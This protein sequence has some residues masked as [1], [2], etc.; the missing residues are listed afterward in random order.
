VV[1]A[2]R[3]LGV[4]ACFVPLHVRGPAEGARS[5]PVHLPGLPA[6]GA[7]RLVRIALF[8]GVLALF[9]RHTS[10][11]DLEQPRVPSEPGEPSEPASSQPLNFLKSASFRAPCGH[12]AG[13]SSGAVAILIASLSAVFTG[14]NM[15][16]SWATYRRVRPR[17]SLKPH[18]VW[19][20]DAKPTR[21]RLSVDLHVRNSGQYPVTL[22]PETQLLVHA[23]DRD[24]L[25][26]WLINPRLWRNF[27][28][29]GY[30]GDLFRHGRA[31]FVYTLIEEGPLEVLP[32]NGVQWHC[33]VPSEYID[34]GYF[35]NPH[36][37]WRAYVR[38]RLSDGTWVASRRTRFLRAPSGVLES[39]E[40]TTT[41]LSS[42]ISTDPHP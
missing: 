37:K 8:L 24:L 21:H 20:E 38:V 12:P 30:I 4:P 23:G 26:R 33:D 2:V 40:T 13:M 10:A 16:A 22:F 7:R 39:W 32:F 19:H 42:T 27:F 31:F 11:L 34:S 25:K 18:F 41:Q 28:R 35:E 29:R 14:A 15:I 5:D 36:I 9:V 17:V 3:T 6:L 1:G